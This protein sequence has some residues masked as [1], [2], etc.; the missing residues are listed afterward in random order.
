MADIEDTQMMTVG[1]G[2]A[3][4]RRYKTSSFNE[5]SPP[6]KKPYASAS[7]ASD[8]SRSST[9]AAAGATAGTTSSNGTQ[10]AVNT[11][12]ASNSSTTIHTSTAGGAAAAAAAA[13]PVA[14]A[15]TEQDDGPLVTLATI[16]SNCKVFHFEAILTSKAAKDWNKGGGANLNMTFSDSTTPNQFKC[17]VFHN[18]D[19]PTKQFN[20]FKERLVVGRTY[21]VYH[22]QVKPTNPTFNKTG[23]PYEMNTASHTRIE[24]VTTGAGY[25]YKKT[26]PFNEVDKTKRDGHCLLG[27]VVKKGGLHETIVAKNGGAEYIKN[28][29]F[30]GDLSM[31]QVKTELW[32][33]ECDDY[34]QG[35][36]EGD[37][38]FCYNFSIQ[39]VSKFN[40]D[41][42]TLGPV[43][44]SGTDFMFRP[45]HDKSKFEL[46]DPA[47]KDSI[48]A[49]EALDIHAG[50][51]FTP[52]MPDLTAMTQSYGNKNTAPPKNCQVI[53]VLNDQTSAM[54]DLQALKLL[55]DG[56]DMKTSNNSVY[57]ET[58]K[59]ELGKKVEER[60]YKFIG[61]VSEA[62]TLSAEQPFVYTACT[63]VKGTFPC[64]RRVVPD[65][66]NPE[67]F[68]CNHCK[69]TM[70]EPRF[71]YCVNLL[72]TDETGSVIA[73][74]FD[75][76]IMK[77]LQDAHNKYNTTS[78]SAVIPISAVD[79]L[80]SEIQCCQSSE[81][82]AAI[83]TSMGQYITNE[84]IDKPYRLTLKGTPDIDMGLKF[85]AVAVECIDFGE[86]LRTFNNIANAMPVQ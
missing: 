4:K 6:S 13:A 75:E 26:T 81:E 58:L 67:L 28:H 34:I 7:H 57:Y 63:N 18:F 53:D 39:Q 24:L 85:T 12:A 59:T 70:D 38:V 51:L 33:K 11:N 2:C 3:F 5:P 64:N 84:L 20:D 15:N 44:R 55:L 32:G 82:D 41:C 17:V 42:L 29:F 45:L 23:H 49:L 22:G 27:K 69:K 37:I 68:Y 36:E 78:K 61:Y 66:K 83:N 25:L 65:Q 43:E 31:H 48:A 73:V 52:V 74:F 72:L 79:L 54:F 50:V 8:G 86:E 77:M 62:L 30:L 21:K 16:N 80:K 40:S 10:P 46:C 71:L 9:N 14:A 47:L 1:S 76:Y 56:E 35:L 19:N 60:R